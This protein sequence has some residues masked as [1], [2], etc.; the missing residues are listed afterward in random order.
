MLK[1]KIYLETGWKNR[2]KQLGSKLFKNDFNIRNNT[3]F[4]STIK[5]SWKVEI[6]HDDNSILIHRFCRYEESCK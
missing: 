4:D 2:K 6:S 3:S 1:Y 5:I